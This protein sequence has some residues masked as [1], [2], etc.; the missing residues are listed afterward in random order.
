MFYYWTILTLGYVYCIFLFP[1]YHSLSV[2]YLVCL[3]HYHSL[4]GLCY[5]RFF[6]VYVIVIVSFDL[7]DACFYCQK[8]S[9]WIFDCVLVNHYCFL[10]S[11][12]HLSLL[13][14]NIPLI[15]QLNNPFLTCFRFLIVSKSP[16]ILT[17]FQTSFLMP[18]SL[19][20]QNIPLFIPNLLF[21]CDGAIIVL[22]LNNT[23][24]LFYY[25]SC[26]RIFLYIYYVLLYLNYVSLFVLHDVNIYVLIAISENCLLFV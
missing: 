10:L 2:Y 11:L 5:L 18:W 13:T 7:Y 23:C 8:I 1:N 22:I 16:R 19:I 12:Y 14:M 25:L 21:L 6:L 24:L 17:T 15:I 9:I 3:N 26:L 20:S 4:A